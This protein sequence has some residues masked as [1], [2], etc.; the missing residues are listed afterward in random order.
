[1]LKQLVTDEEIKEILHRHE[2]EDVARRFTVTALLHFLVTAAL[3]QWKSFRHGADV[4][5]GHGLSGCHYS[6]VSKK[7]GAVPY[8]IIKEIFTLFCSRCNR[9][10]RRQC[11][12]PKELLLIDSTTVTVGKT[13]LLWAPYHGERAGVKLHTAL[14]LSTQILQKVVETTGLKHDS[15]MLDELANKDCIVVADRAYFQIERSDLFC[16]EGQP[17]VIRLKANVELTQRKSLKRVVGEDS[18]IVND[19]TAKLG[20]EQNRSDRRHR[21]V[22]FT[23]YEG[24]I[25]VVTNLYSTCAETVATIYKARWGVE[26]F[27]SLDQTKLNVPRLFGTTK[28]A[29]YNQLFAALLAYVIVNFVYTALAPKVKYQRLSLLSFLRKLL[30]Y[31][32]PLEWQV[33]IQLFSSLTHLPFGYFWLINRRDRLYKMQG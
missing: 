22:E 8:C 28:N 6:T 10:L 9:Q 18:N 3:Q 29:V 13:R 20:S 19:F 24:K 33:V 4:G 7:A 25:R 5:E 23:D 21:I 11:N 14:Q 31:Q 12:F 26:L 1:M 2:Y 17:F 27:F 16:Q 30:S 15:P 32:L